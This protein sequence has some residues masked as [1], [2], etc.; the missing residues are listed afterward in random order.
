MSSA[1]FPGASLIISTYN[2]PDAL[3]LVLESVA[4]QSHLPDEIIIADD[5]SGAETASLVQQYR[6]RLPLPV[7]HS[8][9]E[10]EGFR[11]SRSRNHAI[12]RTTQPYI[13]SIDGDMI[14]HP[15][16][17]AHHLR[18]A[19]PSCFLQGSRVL[20]SPHKTNEIL[21]SKRII[22]SPFEAGLTNRL[23]AVNLHPLGKY[24]SPARKDIKAI[25]GCNMSFWKEDLRRVNGFN[26]EI[27]G[28]GR[29]DSELAAR[30]INVGV[31][32]I[33]LKLCAIA[34]HLDHL[35]SHKNNNKSLDT[36]DYILQNTIILKKT[37][38]EK[39]LSLHGS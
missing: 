26:E 24:F 22:L 14:L 25:R 27:V 38:C 21:A 4:A 6:R 9:Q 10:D 17:I 36:N 30:L 15:Q 28:W 11:L 19:R 29:E 16:F 35:N 12:S 20:L 8:W 33:D 32:R 1:V 31:R 7:L 5:G 13:I 34:Y 23:N 39:G 18:R 37:W 3:A 2:R